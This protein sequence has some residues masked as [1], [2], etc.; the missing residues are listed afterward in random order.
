MNTIEIELSKLIPM[1]ENPRKISKNPDDDMKALA[2][3]IKARG[4][5]HPVIARA[6]PEK[7]GYFDL[8]AGARRHRA[9]AIAG[10]RTIPVNV[11]ELTDRQAAEVTVAENK[12]REDLHVLE[13]ARAVLLLLKYSTLEDAAATLDRTI[14]W[15]KR[16]ANLVDLALCWQE[17]TLD[18]DD[19]SSFFPWGSRHYEQIAR[20]PDAVQ[21]SV[22]KDLKAERFNFPQ[23]YSDLKKYLAEKISLLAGAPWDLVDGELVKGANACARCPKRSSIEPELFA[24][25][26]PVAK[27]NQ[28]DDRCLDAE[29]W[30]KKSEAYV[31]RS[32]VAAREKHGKNVVLIAHDYSDEQKFKAISHWNINGTTKSAKDAV[33]AFDL[34]TMRI[35]WIE[36]PAGK[37]GGGALKGGPLTL[38]DRRAKLQKRREVY[39]VGEVIKILQIVIDSNDTMQAIQN[40][41]ITLETDDVLRGLA[42]FGTKRNVAGAWLTKEGGASDWDCLADVLSI[43]IAHARLLSGLLE[44]FVARLDPRAYDAPHTAEARK[45][46]HYL[47]I[48]FEALLTN[49]TDEIKEPKTWANL[50]EDGTVKKRPKPEAP[51]KPAK[52]KTAKKT[53]KRSPGKLEKKGDNK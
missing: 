52:K 23:S 7:E 14:P 15:V 10:L 2:K 17:A 26:D 12:D 25:L 39:A 18:D 6:H 31:T 42:V 11:L 32:I 27:K 22:Y 29:C 34:K 44:T 8:R 47:D 36:D 4:V 19:D 9:A 35:R 16:R 46:A 1:P 38:K 5:L 40:E 53:A 13:E 30:N 49:A 48:D 51:E 41:G 28:P 33:P 50:N 37:P 43:E 45:I 21:K 20:L 24:D 3:S